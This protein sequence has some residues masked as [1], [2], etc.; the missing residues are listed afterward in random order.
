MNPILEQ[1]YSTILP[2]APY[3]IA[4]YALIWLAL[5]VYVLMIM[6]SYKR[7]RLRWPFGRNSRGAGHRETVAC[8]A[9]REHA[10]IAERNERGAASAALRVRYR[11]RYRP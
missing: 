11:E 4:A 5:F 8:F 1:I 3:V 10:T 6:L 9:L 2:A 7:L